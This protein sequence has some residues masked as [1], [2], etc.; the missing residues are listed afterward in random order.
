[1][2]SQVLGLLR[3]RSSLA[4]GQHESFPESAVVF[5]AG[6]VLLGDDADTKRIVLSGLL[7]GEGELEGVS[8]A[9]FVSSYFILF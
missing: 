2:F 8:C 6:D 4:A 1:M 5:V 7:S 3:L 9:N